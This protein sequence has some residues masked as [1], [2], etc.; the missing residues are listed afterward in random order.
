MRNERSVWIGLVD[1]VPDQ[2]SS[3]FSDAKGAFVN[4]LALAASAD[5][6]DRAVR[7]ALAPVGLN[8]VS[9]EG[10][11]PFEPDSER[12]HATVDLIELSTRLTVANPVICDEFQPYLE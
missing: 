5:D 9:I 11:R 1:V 3:I 8:V 7:V 10:V 6:Y 2:G 12:G 4:V